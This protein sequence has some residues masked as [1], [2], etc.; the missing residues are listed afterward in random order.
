MTRGTVL[1]ET[2]PAGKA[3]DT[4]PGHPE[5]PARLEAVLAGVQGAGV[6]DALVGVEPRPASRAELEAVHGPEYL[7]A[8]EAFCRSGG[9]A[10][11]PDTVASRDSWD[12]ALLSAGGGLDAI[13][14]LR[15][16]QADAAFVAMRPPGH[17]ATPRRAMGFCL[18]NNVAVAAA[19]LAD[20][21]ERVLIVDY[22]AHHGNGTQDVFWADGRVTYISLHQW[23][24]YPGS[25]ALDDTGAGP[26]EGETINLPLPPGATGDVY[27]AAL[28]EVIVPVAERVAPTWLI[29]SAG[30]D[31][32]RADP[33]C[34]L[35]LSAGDFGEI[36]SRL[37][38]LV[39]AGRRLVVLEGG[40]DLTALAHSAGACVAALTGESYNPERV[41]SGGPGREVVDAARRLHLAAA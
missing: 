10:V 14:R 32:H 3:H 22:D 27:L 34:D 19:A 23:P 26:G 36:T 1:V 18:I 8:M 7:D 12:A 13:E 41:T 2:H 15:A 5:R 11:D 29:I 28:D 25:G 30:F 35:E 9:G 38:R 17:H 39:P 20:S 6:A 16:G 4:G 40:Y 37:C 21:G 24:L 33:L 31:G